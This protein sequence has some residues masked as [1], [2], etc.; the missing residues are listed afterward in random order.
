MFLKKIKFFD[1]NEDEFK[2][3]INKNLIRK[4]GK[5]IQ[6]KE[7]DTVTFK[8]F[9]P[10]Y[11][12]I[13]TNYFTK[14]Q[15]IETNTTEITEALTS[16]N[17]FRSYHYG[18]LVIPEDRNLI[19]INDD[20]KATSS[21]RVTA[22]FNFMSEQYEKFISNIDE[23]K[24][25][26]IYLESDPAQTETL[27]DLKFLPRVIPKARHFY[28]F[29]YILAPRYIM[30][31]RE[32]FRNVLFGQNFSMSPGN[33]EREQYPFY[34]RIK[35]N[36]Q[37]TNSFKNTLKEYNFFEQFIEDYIAKGTYDSKT[38]N[39][40]ATKNQK[41]SI[42]RNTYLIYD[43]LEWIQK[44]DFTMDET[45]K[46]IFEPNLKRKSRY[47]YY[48][49]KMAF[50]GKLR[51]FC[52]EKM[53]DVEDILNN[54]AVETETL[55]YKIDKQV[56]GSPRIIQSFWV[57][58]DDGF[59]DL[60]D[61]QIK[62]G[63]KY[64]YTVTAYVLAFG[65]N[66]RISN[67][68]EKGNKTSIRFLMEPS[69]QMI[70]IPNIYSN[71][72]RVIQPPQ[73]VPTVRFVNEKNAHD[74]LRI[75]LNLTL[76]S[77]NQPLQ[78]IRPIESQQETLREEYDRLEERDRFVYNNE[79]ALYEIY[80]TDFQPKSFLELADHKLTQIRNSFPSTG[81]SH[82]DFV[83]PFKKYY[84][85]FRSVNFHGLVSNPTPIYEVELTKDADE[86]FLSAKAVGFLNEETSQTTRRFM[87][88][89]QAIPASQ[90][91]IFESDINGMLDEEGNELQ[92]LRGRAIN[93][94]TLGIAKRPIW[95]KKFK[96][97]I[98]ST[99][100]GKKLDVNIMV[101][102]I[103]KKTMENSK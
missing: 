99:T 75:Y 100:T 86:T 81:A 21:G 20:S 45:D 68:T 72:C 23:T 13:E 82:K 71:I 102:L 28:D 50:V 53:P 47:K 49:D 78:V 30:P 1:A 96:F 8:Y 3:A 32:R 70:E 59:V 34:N 61:T 26:C 98:T 87:R 85:V 57:P 4:N 12:S 27:F 29:N 101:N 69:F 60:I 18:N 55:F 5:F 103:K 48:L 25:P 51:K 33:A 89:M 63:V 93:N 95:G 41:S 77:N 40:E 43:I 83:V 24:I 91:T 58:A 76:N 90:H 54:K 17:T 42:E 64:R 65:C 39:T 66:Y 6:N 37:T 56:D 52:K 80:R 73:P 11:N 36:Y 9:S 92:S 74:Y 16:G 84:Y 67:K 62:Y 97:R 46:V 14:T 2:S 38:F 88:L 22:K 15:T 31:D 10:T 44:S 79:R 94:L 35:F 7:Q 19:A